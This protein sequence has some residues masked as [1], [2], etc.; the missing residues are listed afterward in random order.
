MGINTVFLQGGQDPH[1]DAVLEEVKINYELAPVNGVDKY[2][3]LCQDAIDLA[4]IT[5]VDRYGNYIY[6][7][8]LDDINET[9]DMLRG[10]FGYFYEYSTENIN[11]VQR[12][13]ALRFWIHLILRELT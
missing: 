12:Q 4:N 1:C 5:T 13:M 10:K 2:T 7:I 11:V 9:M 3:H 6:C 8:G